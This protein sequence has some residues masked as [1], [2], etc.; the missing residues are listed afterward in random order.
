MV[1]L[2]I[3]DEYLQIWNKMAVYVDN[4][5]I[6]W[7]G[8]LWC[9]LVADT[10]DELHSFARRLGLQ[11]SWFQSESIYP[12]YDITTTV[13]ERAL[14]LGALDGDRSTMIACAKRLKENLAKEPKQEQLQF[15]F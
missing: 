2:H 8:A 14:E 1:I 13:R 7:R 12:H 3:I 9:H 11:K 10:P 4:E 6:A 15:T 5:Q